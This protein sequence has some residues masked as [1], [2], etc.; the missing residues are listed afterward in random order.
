MFERTARTRLLRLAS[1][2]PVVVITGLD[3]LPLRGAYPAIHGTEVVSCDWHASY[4][5]SYLGRGVWQHS[6]IADCRPS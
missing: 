1:G 6:R 4:T 5:A 3:N 2:F